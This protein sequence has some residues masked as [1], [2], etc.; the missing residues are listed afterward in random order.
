MTTGHRLARLPAAAVLF[1]CT[2]ATFWVAC[3][4]PTPLSP[5]P[6]VAIVT[7]TPAPTPTPTPTPTPPPAAAVPVPEATPASCPIM[8]SW[9]SAIHNVTDSLQQPAR[10]PSVGG[11][12]VI[13]STPLF[14]GRACNSEH[15]FC[16]GRHCEDPR[17]GDW[18]LLEGGSPTEIR[19]DS[20]Q[21]R[22]GPLKAGR[23]RWRVCPH[24]DAIDAEG[25]SVPVGPEPCTVGEFDVP[26]QP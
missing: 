11:H 6:Q 1:T 21:M 14:N 4:S 20:Y 15:N 8:T 24:Y 7:P 16:G 12:V 10:T 13:D 19:E 18:T 23:H 5:Q 17:G 2:A 26:M 3:S 22:I 9:Y 25:D